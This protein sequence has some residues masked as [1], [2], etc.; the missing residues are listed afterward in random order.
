MELSTALAMAEELVREHGLRGW[1]VGL[2]RARTRAGATRFATREITLSAPLTR[3]HSSSTVRDT[4][5]HEI[6]HAMVGPRHGHD[7]VWQAA[8]LRIGASP[9]RC[10]PDSAPTLPGPWVGTCPAGHQ[11]T[12][13]RRPTRVLLCGRCPGPARERAMR[14]RH[15][16][17][18]VPMH[19]NFRAEWARLV[20]GKAHPHSDQLRPGDQVR[21]VAPGRYLG[22]TGTIVRRGRTRYHVRLGPGVLTVPFALVE[23]LAA[24]DGLLQD[25]G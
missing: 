16:G 20:E 4:V 13:H 1:T 24:V 2:D 25:S 15:H 23:P 21:V 17:R 3:L 19:P 5:L 12:R 6:A 8:A 10:L 14:W 7:R 11:L 18:E 9:Q 22:T